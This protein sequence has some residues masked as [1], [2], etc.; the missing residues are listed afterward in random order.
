MYSHEF[1]LLYLP[2]LSQHQIITVILENWTITGKV[3]T[4]MVLNRFLNTF[5][6]YNQFVWSLQLHKNVFLYCFQPLLILK[7]RC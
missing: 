3:T 1:Y 2:P 6:I 5:N 4:G 7:V